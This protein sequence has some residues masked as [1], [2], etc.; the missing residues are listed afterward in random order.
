MSCACLTVDKVIAALAI[1]KSAFTRG[2][3]PPGLSAMVSPG[4]KFTT[5][6]SYCSSGGFEITLAIHDELWLK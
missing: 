6:D 5:D 4:C 3:L 2:E 1:L